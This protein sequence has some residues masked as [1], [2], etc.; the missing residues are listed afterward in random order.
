M[1]EPL[2]NLQEAARLLRMHP[3]TLK[4]R[5][6][7]GEIPGHKIGKRWYF[8]ES[9]LDAWVGAQVRSEQTQTTPR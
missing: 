3:E 7:Q 5:A 1:F 8:R 4:R 6:R 2:L 9:E